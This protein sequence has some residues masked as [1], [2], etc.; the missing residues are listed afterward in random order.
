MVAVAFAHDLLLDGSVYKSRRSDSRSHGGSVAYVP[1]VQGQQTGPQLAPVNRVT[2]HRGA[3]ASRKVA[4]G[5]I[6]WTRNGWTCDPGLVLPGPLVNTVAWPGTAADG[7]IVAFVEQDGDLYAIGGRRVARIP[8]GSG[9]AVAEQ[10][11]G[12]GFVATGARLFKA[13]FYV[14]G[15]S[16]GNLW[17][18]LAGGAWSN[19]MVGAAVQRGYLSSVFWSLGGVTAE[20]LVG[21]VG[22]TGIQYVDAT[23]DPLDAAQWLPAVAIDVGPHPITS[24]V[25]TRDHVYIATT[26]GLK[27]LDVTGI[28]P[29]L[30]P[31]VERNVLSTNGTATLADRGWIYYG[32]GYGLIRVRVG[33]QYDYAQV[34]DV[35]PKV[36]LPD[37]TPV[38]GL[39]MA[40]ARYGPWII[41]AQWDATAGVGGTTYVSWGREASSDEAGPMAWNCSP[42]VLVG[43][44]VTRLHVSGLV[45]GNPRLW[46]GVTD[47]ATRSLRWCDLAQQTPYQD[48]RNGR[49]YRFATS[50]DL[51]ESYEDWGDDTLPK[52]VPDVAAEAENLGPGTSLVISAAVDGSTVYSG[53]GTL[54]SSPRARLT[55]VTTLRGSRIQVA[56][57]GTGTPAAPP[58]L[59]KV[60]VR[61]IPQPDLREVRQYQVV[62]G[63]AVR[64]A[65]GGT[66]GVDPLVR[67]GALKALTAGGPVSLR[68]EDGQNLSVQVTRFGPI[69]EV[70]LDATGRGERVVVATLELAVMATVGSASA[71]DG[72]AALD[73]AVWRLD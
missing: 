63:R 44:K 8:A 33:N 43:Q 25:Q 58:I 26:G 1:Q 73:S 56:Y 19:A 31:Q 12:A 70:D 27:D 59:R 57:S 42:V 4:P 69:Q 72:A 9:V 50:F 37:E 61:A 55:P 54:N 17:R 62:L 40:I 67:R 38:T 34:Q 22:T 30:T 60:S 13:G 5:M 6:A 49:T 29:N 15:G 48:L 32:F 52:I 24:L 68:D 71:L 41:L 64:Q 14:G 47:G 36:G 51:Y 45:T 10:D 3:G 16:T 2:W 39:P 7:D 46:M 23:K 66:D 11:L 53:V 18:K 21:S 20:R 28:A 65:G 35:T